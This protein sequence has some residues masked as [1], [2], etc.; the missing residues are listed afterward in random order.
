MRGC[1]HHLGDRC[2]IWTDARC[3]QLVLFGLTPRCLL[4]LCRCRRHDVDRSQK[5]EDMPY[6]RLMAIARPQFTRS[7]AHA[8]A[9][10]VGLSRPCNRR[11]PSTRAGSM[12]RPSAL[13][14]FC[15]A[16]SLPQIANA[17][18]CLSLGSGSKN[19]SRSV[20]LR[21][22]RLPPAAYRLPPIMPYQR[23]IRKRNLP[24]RPPPQALRWRP[25]TRRAWP[26]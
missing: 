22:Q 13:L 19:Y 6:F 14:V 24:A 10:T 26:L 4:H 8:S 15:M 9:C 12:L 20:P 1:T 3:L 23:V 17:F 16:F 21:A 25:M 18:F 5:W 7:T 2:Q 11:R